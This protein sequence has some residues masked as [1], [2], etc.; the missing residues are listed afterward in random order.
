VN[1][2]LDRLGQE[3]ILSLDDNT[4]EANLAK[5]TVP[6][7]FGEVQRKFTWRRLK[8]RAR[9]AADTTKPI[10]G[11]QERYRLPANFLR[12]LSLEVNGCPLESYELEGEFILCDETG[13]LDLRYLEYN[14][15]PNKWD[16]LLQSVIATRLA[17]NM[18]EK[19]TGSNTKKA[20][21]GAELRQLMS[22]ARHTNGREGHPEVV[23]NNVSF[24]N[25]RFK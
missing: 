16:Q 2:A 23:A 21:L 25:A 18:C 14:D 6:F 4:T 13:P 1:L 8:A 22:E 9:L 3:P 15:D 24:V 5:R 17:Y 11:F 7:V 20:E 12:M 19:L 10:F